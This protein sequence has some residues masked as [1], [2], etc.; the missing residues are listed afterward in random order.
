MN[1]NSREDRI[2]LCFTVN[3]KHYESGAL[4]RMIQAGIRFY[5]I[6]LGRTDAAVCRS[7]CRELR[8]TA[9]AYRCPVQ[10][11]VDLPGAKARIAG[12]QPYAAKTGAEERLCFTETGVLRSDAEWLRTALHEGDVIRIGRK[13]VQAEVTALMPD[14]A[15]LRFTAP[16]I[17]KPRDMISAANRSMEL[18]QMTQQD[19]HLLE[20]LAGVDFDLLAVSFTQCGEQIRNVRARMRELGYSAQIRIAAKIEEAAGIA[21]YAEIGRAA[22]GIMVGRGDMSELLGMDHANAFITELQT[23]WTRNGRL[24]ILASY[25]FQDVVAETGG[26]DPALLQHAAAGAD[27]FVTD[28]SSYYD[29]KKIY[30]AYNKCFGSRP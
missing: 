14:A 19:Q 5:R 27:Y 2:P 4:R 30:D 9:A 29:W 11:E 25:Y 23:N 7:M 10:I 16:G 24:L 6:N 17:I 18:P 3:R 26:V 1:M 12:V 21:N 28:E 15:H 8:Q 13:G 22:D 20:A